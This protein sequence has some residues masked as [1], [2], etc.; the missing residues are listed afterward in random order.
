MR[1]YKVTVTTDGSGNATAYSPRVSGKLN[2][3]I[4]VPDGTNPFA[5]TVDMTITA[6]ATGESLISRTNVSAAFNAYPRVATAAADGTAALFAAAGTAVQ[7]K[8]AIGNDRIKIV[9]AQGGATKSGAFHF[10]VD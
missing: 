8:L 3:V 5:N 1:R 10:L 2:S 4:Y 9:L 7:D 6:E